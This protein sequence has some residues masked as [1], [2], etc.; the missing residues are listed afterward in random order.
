LSSTRKQSN[1]VC[2]KHRE[3]RIRK[4][5][6][7]DSGVSFRNSSEK[8]L[9]DSN[10][11]DRCTSLRSY[12]ELFISQIS[13]H[14]TSSQLTISSKPNGR[15]VTH[16]IVAATVRM[17]LRSNKTR[18]DEV[19]YKNIHISTNILWQVFHI[20]TKLIPYKFASVN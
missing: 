11:T 17:A 7:P 6:A 14:Y 4:I 13:H 19:H 8:A 10:T 20:L 16:F 5:N 15:E 12:K 3:I 18:S 1:S 2:R 9:P